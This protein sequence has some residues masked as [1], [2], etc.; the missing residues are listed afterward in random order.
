M[1]K[2]PKLAGGQRTMN[3]KIG[4]DPV[5]LMPFDP[6]GSGEGH[7]KYGVGPLFEVKGPAMP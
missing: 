5:R 1:N 7:A 6:L 4:S 3:G 2:R